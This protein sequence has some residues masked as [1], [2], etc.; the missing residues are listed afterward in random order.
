VA[1]EW[2]QNVRERSIKP[3]I[4]FTQDAIVVNV[5]MEQ[6]SEWSA[7]KSLHNPMADR[8]RPPKVKIEE[9]S[10]WDRRGEID[11]DVCK[12]NDIRLPA[13]HSSSPSYV[14][15]ENIFIY[16]IRKALKVVLIPAREDSRL[17]VA[18][19]FVVKPF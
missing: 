11:D 15:F 16:R 19:G 6:K 1:H 9:N 5:V 12:K 4:L 3:S 10:T 18:V 7:I 2:F 14:W 8:M 13:D 17:E